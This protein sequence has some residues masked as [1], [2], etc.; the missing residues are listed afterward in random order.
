MTRPVPASPPPR[1]IG[2]QIYT[3]PTYDGVHPLAIPRVPTV[4]AL[5]RAMGWLDPAIYHTSPRAKPKALRSFHTQTYI[6][7][8][9]RVEATQA[10]TAADRE[11]HG[12]G[13]LSNPVHPLM[14]RRPATAAGGSLLGAEL[15]AGGGVVY[16]PGGGTH[17]GHA[18][19]AG[20][21]CYLNDP[22]LAILRLKALGLSRIAYVDI[23]AHHCDGVQDAFDGAEG[24]RIVSV[25]EAKRWPFTGGVD[26]TAGGVAFNIPAPRGFNDT[27]FAFLLDEVI[28]PAIAAHRPE[29]VVLQC[30]ADAV[31]ED[32]LSR[33]A[34]SNGSHW[35]AV[36][37]LRALA[38][39]M[40]VLGGGGYNPWSVGRL[41]TGV[42]A[43]L[44][45]AEI[46][47]PAEAL[48]PAAQDIL[49]ALTWRRSGGKNPPEHWFTT[50]ADRPREGEI[51]PELR[52]IAATLRR[53]L[54]A[55][56]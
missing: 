18:D 56:H 14:Y 12:L 35:R 13:T 6:D 30:G 54:P 45:G 36:S 9:Q 24:I 33:L 3:R 42:W 49:R 43:T 27:G 7:T 47:G 17:H 2:S 53:R 48:P 34:L 10:A 40:L 5:S 19:R 38:P 46:P 26:D 25:H 37:E 41:W 44:S 21:F 15:I 39:R 8:L 28:L 11:R 16:N 4:I 20:G 1:F 50:L 29:A 51:Q 31:L 32:P 23:D 52:D 55:Y 22:V